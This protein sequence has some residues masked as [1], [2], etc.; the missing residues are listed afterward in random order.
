[1]K[2]SFKLRISALLLSFCLLFTA[3]FPAASAAQ[4]PALGTV[5][6]TCPTVYI[7]G[8][9][10]GDIYANLGTSEEKVVWPVSE[11]SIKTAVAA[12][13]KPLLAL[14]VD[15][16]TFEDGLVEV[17]NILFEGAHNNPDGSPKEGTGI[18]W[19]YPTTA[20]LT[21]YNNFRYDWRMDPLVVA[22]E[23]AQYIDFVLEYTESEK[24][25]IECHSMGGVIFLAYAAKYGLDKIH[26]AILDSVAVYGES[27]MSKLF[28][29]NVVMDGEAVYSYL[30]Y[31]MTGLEQEQLVDFIFDALFAAGV[32]DIVEI[33]SEELVRR[34]IDRAA[35][36]CLIPLFGRWL[37]MWAMIPDDSYEDCIDY[38][39][40]TVLADESAEYA[41]L[42]NRVNAYNSLVRPYR[43]DIL[44]TLA[45]TDNLMVISRYGFSMAPVTDQ[46]Q[47]MSD[48]TIDTKYTSFGATAAPYGKQL[49]DEYVETHKDLGYLSPDNMVDASTCRYPD[50]T[51]FIK[52]RPHS[53]GTDF[54][55]DLKRAV[56]FADCSID[57]HSYE[58]FP[59]YMI[60]KNGEVLPFTDYK[61]PRPNL[62]YSY[63]LFMQ[64]LRDRIEEVFKTII[65]KLQS[66]FLIPSNV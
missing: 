25:A 27:Y 28:T 42:K 57:I 14:L 58:E 48:G 63:G 65:A 4:I 6:A 41:E 16:E 38:V 47:S 15:Y 30:L 60:D 43:E 21:E 64:M 3:V 5:E 62:L 31:A 9:G 1:M 8:F 12:A 26:G 23:L 35:K 50:I 40:N 55:N 45:E 34:S 13:I 24:V 19:D 61:E 56:L 59:Q 46:W 39:F 17:V 20:S 49:S 10:C 7:H 36:E 53:H 22:D 33:L 37:G 2:I 51:W 32:F 29:G 11:E 66:V 18:H 54:M 44:D 52:N